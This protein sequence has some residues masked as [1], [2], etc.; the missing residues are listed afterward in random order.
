MT[1]DMLLEVEVATTGGTTT[2]DHT[3]ENATGMM[4][5]IVNG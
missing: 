2:D 1:T 3:A 5:E 4:T